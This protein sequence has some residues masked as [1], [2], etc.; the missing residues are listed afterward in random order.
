[1]LFLS[2]DTAEGREPNSAVRVPAVG[3][4]AVGHV[5]EGVGVAAVRRALPPVVLSAVHPLDAVRG[6]LEPRELAVPA[7]GRAVGV[8]HAAEHLLLAEEAEPVRALSN[9]RT[10]PIGRPRLELLEDAAQRCRDGVAVRLVAP[11]AARASVPSAAVGVG[12]VH[13]SV[14]A[15]AVLLENHEV[16]L[17]PVRQRVVARV[18]EHELD[19][20]GR[21][22]LADASRGHGR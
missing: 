8:G 10:R 13:V 2:L 5:A 3:G 22:A 20:L 15:E 21:V 11:R 7:L 14:L 6:G 19:A 18:G 9:A 12:I 1:M 16:A 4:A 17:L